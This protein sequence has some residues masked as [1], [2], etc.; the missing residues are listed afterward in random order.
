V[1]PRSIAWNAVVFD[2]LDERTSR[3][4]IA[5]IPRR[6]LDEFLLTLD[7]G[8]LDGTIDAFLASP[9]AERTLVDAS[10]AGEPQL[11]DGIGRPDAVVPPE[12][13][14]HGLARLG[15]SGGGS[16][17]D[18]RRDKSRRPPP[19]RGRLIVG[20][21]VVVAVVAIA[22][23]ALAARSNSS[24]TQAVSA[25]TLGTDSTVPQPSASVSTAASDAG[26]PLTVDACSLLSEGDIKAYADSIGGDYHA[27]PPFLPSPTGSSSKRSDPAKQRFCT[28]RFLSA[29]AD[30][31]ASADAEVDVVVDKLDKEDIDRAC[32]LLSTSGPV[33]VFDGVGDHAEATSATGCVRVGDVT[34]HLLYGGVTQNLT[35]DSAVIEHLLAV[36][37]SG[38]GDTPPPPATTPVTDPA[39]VT[40]PA[41]TVPPDEPPSGGGGVVGPIAHG[42][43]VGTG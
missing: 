14:G 28:W 22:G 27:Q 26:S 41:A 18:S 33:R 24:D 39:P 20:A 13:G 6:V 19:R 40:E 25:V 23:V 43:E 35:G 8:T 7:A 34:A 21:A 5:C 1:E 38:L 42:T 31:S 2:I 15:G 30:G 3:T 4:A 36:L 29:T 32:H 11:F 17:A 9:S 16:P 10:Q 12:R 37:A